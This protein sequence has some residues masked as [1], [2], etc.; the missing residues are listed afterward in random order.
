MY[1]CF[2][3]FQYL[4]NSADAQALSHTQTHRLPGSGLRL[5]HVWTEAHLRLH[6]KGLVHHEEFQ[7]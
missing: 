4:E 6:S 1:A 3:V 5:L 7:S 2:Q